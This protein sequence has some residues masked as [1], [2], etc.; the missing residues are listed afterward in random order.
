MD[1]QGVVTQMSTGGYDVFFSDISSE[2]CS[3]NFWCV[4]KHLY[5]ETVPV[6]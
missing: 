1:V 3:V 6:D 4:I 5:K 2:R